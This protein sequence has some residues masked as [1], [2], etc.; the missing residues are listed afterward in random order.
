MPP[1]YVYAFDSCTH[2]CSHQPQFLSPQEV[3]SCPSTACPSRSP[4][5]SETPLGMP[6]NG[7]LLH[8]PL[9]IW[10]CVLNTMPVRFIKVTVCVSRS[11][12]F[13]TEPECSTTLT[14]STCVLPVKDMWAA[15]GRGRNGHRCVSTRHRQLDGPLAPFLLGQ[16][17]EVQNLG[18]GV[19]LGL[20]RNAQT[21]FQSGLPVSLKLPPPCPPALGGLTLITGSMCVTDRCLPRPR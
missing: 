12:L 18:H 1:F 20:L 21:V 6:M 17:S 13:T 11:F 5:H 15:P 2:P 9:C 3:R 14:Q 4:T 8:M 16:V 7:V 19:A 10:L